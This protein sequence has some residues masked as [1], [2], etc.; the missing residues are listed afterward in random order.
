MSFF[1][2]GN[3]PH[4]STSNF[5]EG[6]RLRILSIAFALAAVGENSVGGAEQIVACIDRALVAAGHESVL[7]AGADSAVCGSLFSTPPVPEHVNHN[8]YY[9][10]RY[11]E[12]WRKINAA[13]A[14]GPVDLVH[15][16]GIDFH[17]F[18]PDI[19]VP[20]LATLHLPPSWYPQHI[21]SRK[22]YL[23]MNCVSATQRMATPDS[24]AMA[25]TIVNGVTIPGVEPLPATER[26]GA[27]ILG[28]ICPEKGTHVAIAAARK[29][30]VALTIAGRAFGYPEHVAYF[31]NEVLP[32]IG[33]QTKFI[34]QIGYREKVQLLR[35]AQ[36][37][38]VP[39][40]A[41]ETS[42]LVSMEA[43]ACGTPVIAMNSGAL[44]EIVENGK[45][46]LIV[47]SG[48]EMAD[49]IG[50][51]SAIDPRLCRRAAIE[52][53]SADRMVCEYLKLYEQLIRR[54]DSM[55]V[56]TAAGIDCQNL[57]SPNC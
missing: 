5:G 3:G 50:A 40:L 25:G 23:Y 42:S 51:I 45:T 38:L 44:P 21:F 4:R 56:T 24:P 15:M 8:E 55:I 43:L 35:R 10:F 41:P 52:R 14:S 20:V 47:N 17:E 30:G 46:G 11:V 27:V 57:T 22:R 16:H 34:G 18:I 1:R 28:R 29:T 26:A 39:S 49:A 6:W 33:S 7:V 31:E 32:H 13:L 9:R 37:L 53:F 48:D 19:D 2:D 54:S 36:C 12:H